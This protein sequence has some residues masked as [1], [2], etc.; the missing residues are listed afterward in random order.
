MNRIRK[1]SRMVFMSAISVFAISGL[2]T[3]LAAG[4]V[5]F[6]TSTNDGCTG[7][8]CQTSCSN[9][10][11]VET[12]ECPDMCPGINASNSVTG[13]NSINRNNIDVNE[14]S[15]ISVV[16]EAEARNDFDIDADAGFGNVANNTSV[17]NIMGGDING[18]LSAVT[19]LNSGTI[20]L[21]SGAS[22]EDVSIWLGNNLTG[23]DSINVND[24]NVDRNSDVRIRNEAEARN[25]LDLNAN[26]GGNRVSN[27][28]CVGDL[29]SGDIDVSAS[30]TTNLN[31]GTNNL[32]I[33]TSMPGVSVN[34]S[35]GTTGPNSSNRNNADI[36]MNRNICVENT[37]T[38]SNN[39]D[40]DLN[41]G[42]N[43]I[44]HNTVV[45]N[46]STGNVGF[47]LNAVTNAN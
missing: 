44:G 45:G 32:T 43:T 46:V 14:S 5:S 37:A 36:D 33:P 17:G 39:F 13:P 4:T 41:S 10:G 34:F 6:N 8:S 23:P 7:A 26:T 15:E 40:V 25:N 22:D 38:V 24:V 47:T 18:S 35:N 31:Q 21:I 2:S 11:T 42:K 3:A 20:D 1:I 19:N 29:S 30:F 28:T 16:N 12:G 9:C 27:N